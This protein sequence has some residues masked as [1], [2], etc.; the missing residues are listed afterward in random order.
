MSKSLIPTS[1]RALS[2]PNQSGCPSAM[3]SSTQKQTPV[4]F[5]NRQGLT[6]FGI[7]EEPVDVPST[8][9]AVLLLSPG[10]KMRVGPQGLYRRISRELVALGLPVLRFD[11]YGLGD[12]EGGLPEELLRDVYNHIEV[13]RFVDDTVDAMDW[14][15]KTR[16]T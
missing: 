10:V 14:M 2:R 11:F 15:Q 16:G 6:L 8:D 3:K 12:S 4:T 7:L 9:V 1:V 13:G 5:L